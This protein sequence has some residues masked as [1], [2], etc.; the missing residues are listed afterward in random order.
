MA[1]RILVVD[2]E[3]K[4]LSSLKDLLINEGYDVSIQSD[5]S[6]ISELVK[7]GDFSLLILDLM[8]PE[9]NGLE[10]CKQIR[11]HSD[12][13]IIM[14]T[15]RGE[16]IDKLLGLELGADD[17]ITKPFSPRELAARV[18]AIL[19]RIDRSNQRLNQL[20]NAGPITIDIAQYEGWI[21]GNSLDLT[22]TE[23]KILHLLMT[24]PN[25]VFSR[26]QILEYVFGDAYEGYERT[27]DTHISN[28][29]RKIDL[30]D[31]DS[32]IRSV[33]GV[34]YKYIEKRDLP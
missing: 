33:Y 15:A 10:V 9:M 23:L 26:L 19:R 5:S 32:L 24:H 1:N 8:M 14:L 27:I 13:P 3:E 34:G 22:P 29:R 21:N 31:E 30:G 12:I 11:K 2:D 20:V 25:Q 18:K 28:I 17:Y 6:K 16:E 4:I 7:R